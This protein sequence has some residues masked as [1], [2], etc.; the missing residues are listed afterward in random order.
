M[1]AALG[2]AALTL[3]GCA[4]R[5][6]LPADPA[7]R[8]DPI[9]FFAGRSAG[10]ASLDTIFAS[11]VRVSVTSA[12]RIDRRGALV[13][14]QAIREGDK[15]ERKRRWV[16]RRGPGGRFD[17]TLTDAEGPVEVK[18]AGPRA[19]IRY[20]MKNGFGIEQH[21]AMQRDRRTLLNR[22]VVTRFGVRVARLDETIRK[23]D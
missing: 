15:P 3:A 8:L 1:R 6:E 7:A 20:R 11:P 19:T 5:A 2:A 9:A 12:G 21:L 17:G 23:L 10:V 22:L 14:D 18:V 16:M 4:Q 13:L